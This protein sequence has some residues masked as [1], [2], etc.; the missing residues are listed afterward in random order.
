MASVELIFNG[1]T[2]TIQCKENDTI[3]EIL[4]N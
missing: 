1:A 3:K 2:T 4:I